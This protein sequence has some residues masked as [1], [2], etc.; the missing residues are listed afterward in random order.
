M[1]KKQFDI[2]VKNGNYTNQAGEQKNRYKT[3]GMVMQNDDGSQF[4]LLDPTVNLAGFQR[5][6]G[7]D[8]LIGSFFEPYQD[9]G[10]APQQQQA[11]R[12]QGQTNSQG[13][14]SNGQQYGQQQQQPQG[15][16]Q[17]PSQQLAQKREQAKQQVNPAA[18]MSQEFD[19]DLPF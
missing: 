16:F 14:K 2:K 4:A 17:Q 3:V 12:Q 7:K 11:P 10:Q 9:N 15:G 19:D 8:M 18:P 1:A 6:T 13:F 5:D